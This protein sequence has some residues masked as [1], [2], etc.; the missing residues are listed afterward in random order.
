MSDQVRLLKSVPLFSSLPE[1]E[2]EILAETLETVE[3]PP[4]HLL[5]R[6]G[7]RGDNFYILK[8][9]K[10]EVIQALDTAAQRELAL[11][12]PGEFVGEMG[13][14]TQQGLRTA[15]V[16]VS[17][18]TKLWKLHRSE[19]DALLSRYPLLGYE[20]VRVLSMR[21]NQAHD[22]AIQELMEKNKRLREAYEELQAAQAQL[23]EKE[24]ME[25]ELQVARQI[26]MSI[27]PDEMPHLSGFDFGALIQPARMVG[28]D[29]YDFIPVSEDRLAVLIGDVTD[30]G[31]PAA[32][33]M[34]QVHA[35]LRAEIVRGRSPR[36]T[37]L[38]VNRHLLEMNTRG[39]FVTLVY[40]LLDRRNSEFV[41]VRAG[42]ELP[43]VCPPGGD[44]QTLPMKP[45]QPLGIL[46]DPVLDEQLVKLEPGSILFLYTDGV[47]E[48]HDFQGIPFG[49]DE[50]LGV[51]GAMRN[52]T[53]QKVCDL[54]LEN[55]VAYRRG[56]ALEDD[57]TLLAV[58]ADA[59]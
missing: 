40:G 29:F 32:L 11:R 28:G 46:D 26:Q 59:G 27:L 8:E 22:H 35:L 36:S 43:V 15:S 13:L 17:E 10:V 25:R 2:L 7:D 21:L 49:L 47:T 58:K 56:A 39:Y 54:L 14:L 38:A 18:K 3:Y 41:Y 45:G 31:V 37:L 57:V 34:A 9:G 5:L 20:M 16:R 33:F 30:K 23:V 1:S 48:E 52:Q 24:R 6:E 42:H 19:F 4:G 44:V 53:A 51:L 12:G 50:L 55:L